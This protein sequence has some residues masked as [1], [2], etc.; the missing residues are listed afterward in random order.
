MADRPSNEARR[1]DQER[2]LG[3]IRG[4]NCVI[5]GLLRPGSKTGHVGTTVV[6]AAAPCAGNGLRGAKALIS[7]KG[8]DPG[9]FALRR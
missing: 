8:I 1:N 6:R 9:K 5:H 7:E 4:P 3:E 2:D